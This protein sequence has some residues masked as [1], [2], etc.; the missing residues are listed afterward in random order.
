LRLQPKDGD[1]FLFFPAR[2]DGT[3]DKIAVHAS[4]PVITNTRGL[5]AVVT[6]SGDGG[7][8]KEVVQQWFHE[9]PLSSVSALYPEHS[10]EAL[11]LLGARRGKG[12][13]A[14]SKRRKE[15]ARREGEG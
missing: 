10:K 9:E 5:S 4:C 15:K 6:E 11:A 2:Y 14:S 7:R 1:A 8:A 3:K 12:K 13:R